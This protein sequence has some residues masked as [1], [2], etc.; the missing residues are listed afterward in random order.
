MRTASATRAVIEGSGAFLA[1]GGGLRR[2]F[3]CDVSAL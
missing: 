3:F 2:L 1:L